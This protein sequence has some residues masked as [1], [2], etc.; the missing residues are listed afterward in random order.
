[1]MDGLE[2]DLQN[3]EDGAPLRVR[4]GDT[5]DFRARF[6]DARMNRPFVGRSLG[7]VEIIAVEILHDQ[8]VA[9]DAAGAHVS[10][11]N[12]RVRAGYAHA[13]MT[14]AVGHTFVIENMTSGDQ[15]FPQL[16]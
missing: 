13:D 12:E 14:V 8:A 2:L 7:A 16:F 15:F 9:G 6:Q 3:T 4:V 1:M 10:D 11:G 5:D